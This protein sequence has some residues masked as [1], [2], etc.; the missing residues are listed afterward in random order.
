MANSEKSRFE[1][2]TLKEESGGPSRGPPEQWAAVSTVSELNKVPPQNA[3][4]DVPVL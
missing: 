1:G 4:P 3:Q 2:C